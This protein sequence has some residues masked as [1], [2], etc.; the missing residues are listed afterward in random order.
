MMK[1]TTRCAALAGLMATALAGV[2]SAQRAT[3][4]FIPVGK[5]PGVSGTSAYMG[6]ILAVDV[7]RRTVTVR[8][9]RG[10]TAI[11]VSQSTRIWLDRSGQRQPATVG[12]LADL[13]VGWTVEV[14]YLDPAKKEGAEWIKV[15]VPAGS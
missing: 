9:A 2:A 10:E 7:A 11:K 12:T 1:I 14:K 3:E 15:A 5:S 6:S 4:Q 8:G 13:Q